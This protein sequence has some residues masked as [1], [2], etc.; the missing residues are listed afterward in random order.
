MLTIP[1][2]ANENTQEGRLAN[3]RGELSDQQKTRLLHE[4]DMSRQPVFKWPSLQ[5]LPL[6]LLSLFIASFTVTTSDLEQWIPVWLGLALLV[7]AAYGAVKLWTQLRFILRERPQLMSIHQ[8]LTANDYQIE[9]WEGPVQFIIHP[10]PYSIDGK[11]VYQDTHFIQTP[12]HS[13]PV[14]KTLWDQFRNHAEDGLILHYLTNPLVTLLSVERILLDEPPEAP[15]DAELA[16]VIG[17]GDDGELIYEEQS[18]QSHR[19]LR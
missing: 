8:R 10:K 1:L 12:L 4:V 17:I 6:F 11:Q 13:F 5:G 19:S 7:G 14:T 15:T 16:T 18:D 3:I 2:G 9:S